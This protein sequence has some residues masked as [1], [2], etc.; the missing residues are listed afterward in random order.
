ML[1]ELIIL[2]KLLFNSKP[3]QVLGKE[4]EVME[5]KHFPFGKY[6]YMSWCGKLIAKKE[7][8]D[9]IRAF[10]NTPSGK[11]IFTHEYGHAVQAESEH[12]DNWLRYYLAYFW[13]WIKHCP[14]IAP[15]HACYYF[16]RYEAE[17][18]A[19]QHNP[20][21]WKYYHRG[22]LRSKY[23]IK[24]PRKLWKSLGGTSAKWKEYIRTL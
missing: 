22:N 16:N 2:I 24:K 6:T 14:W 18:F 3:S 7:N 20:D 23:T 9:K 19:N 5:M 11:E 1:K 4:L 21:Y 8:A 12:G 10:K 17:A 13:H 15:A